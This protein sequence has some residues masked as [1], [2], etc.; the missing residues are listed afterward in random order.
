MSAFLHFSR[1]SLIAPRPVVEAG[2]NRPH[3][4][5]ET[6]PRFLTPNMDQ[7]RTDRH[8]NFAQERGA[9]DV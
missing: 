1:G 7:E 2:A 8:G 4:S 9:Q 5:L 6:N 3:R